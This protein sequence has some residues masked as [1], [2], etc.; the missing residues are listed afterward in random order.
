[1]A[2]FT[3]LNA[4]IAA[5]ST[6]QQAVS[7]AIA[8]ND[9]AI[10]AEIQALKA[11]LTTGANGGIDQGAVDATLANIVALSA[12]NVVHA[13]SIAKQTE[14]LSAAVPVAET[15]KPATPTFSQAAVG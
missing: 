5:L 10:S 9:Q 2:G 1:M 13:T 4:E 12:N 6:K 15:T 11:A 14:D 3:K 8:D 7:V